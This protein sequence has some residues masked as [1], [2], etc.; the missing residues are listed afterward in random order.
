MNVDNTSPYATFRVTE[1]DEPA[2]TAYV[3]VAEL[4]KPTSPLLF[5]V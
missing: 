5:A 2:T 4:S 1:C 3:M